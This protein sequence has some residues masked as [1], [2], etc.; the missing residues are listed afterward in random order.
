MTEQSRLSIGD[1]VLI[2][3]G[4]DDENTG[5]LV[6]S[7]ED[8]VNERML[9]TVKIENRLWVGPA[10]RVFSTGTTA[11]DAREL[12][13]E[14]EA[15]QSDELLVQQAQREEEERRLTEAEDVEEAEPTEE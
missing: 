2:I 6:G 7:N 10:N 14:Y 9:Y 5:V 4:A 12:L 3:T 13:R 8:T 15:K 1:E 11:E